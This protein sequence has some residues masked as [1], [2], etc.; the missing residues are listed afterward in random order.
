MNTPEM[1]E[2]YLVVN[3]KSGKN[4][5]PEDGNTSSGTDLKQNTTTD[6]Q[7]QWLFMPTSMLSTT[8]TEYFVFNK[9]AARLAAPKQSEDD[10]EDAKLKLYDYT[11][12]KAQK[13]TPD[14]SGSSSDAGA[15]TNYFSDYVMGIKGNSKDSGKQV[16]QKAADDENAS[17]LWTI[18]SQ[19]TFTLP[20]VQKG[21]YNANAIP[22][23]P[24]PDENGNVESSSK[25]YLI[26]E[27][28]TPFYMVNDP[29]RDIQNQIQNTP[30]Y[31]MRREQYWNLIHQL[32][33][34]ASS[35]GTETF[36]Y[37]YGVTESTNLSIQDTMGIT[38]TQTSG[39]DYVIGSS[40]VTSSF[41]EELEVAFDESGTQSTISTT[42]TSYNI[43][44]GEPMTYCS[45]QLVD[46]YTLFDAKGDTVKNGNWSNNTVKISET[47]APYVVNTTN[48]EGCIRD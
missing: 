32:V 21:E 18:D 3:D 28:L 36:E 5:K 6:D 41:T 30:Y 16:M 37:E 43:T 25:R 13:W 14:V 40:S 8:N 10:K 34:D 44:E 4:L 38:I 12:D 39:F 17:R 19:S 11:G 15:I 24:I 45:W 23:P 29:E 27:S 22:S 48:V 35:S 2:F 31:V 26:G 9:K 46:V 7:A 47:S 1:N 33:T 42:T 20:T